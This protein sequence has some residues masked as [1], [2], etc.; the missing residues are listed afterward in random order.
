MAATADQVAEFLVAM[1]SGSPAPGSTAG[2]GRPLAIGTIRVIRAA[3]NHRYREA[4]LNSPARDTRVVTVM[5]GLE[6]L[7]GRQPRQAKALREREIVRIVSRC[8]EL[9]ARRQRRVI[10]VRDAAVVAVGFAAALRRSEICALEVA[11]VEFVRRGQDVSGMFVHIR[12]SKMDQ[13]GRG[14]TIAVPEGERIRPVGRLLEWLAVSG[15]DRGPLFRTLRRGGHVQGRPMHPSDIARLVKRWVKA[16][17]LDPE[18]YSGHSLRAGF[19]TSAAV[20]RA[21]L[22]KIMEVTRHKSADTV[23]RYV[24]QAD[25]FEDHAG[26][27]FL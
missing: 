9:A 5:R 11:D 16:I 8:D 25:A 22:D 27:G 15:V 7:A 3:I 20:H 19:V 2:V 17:G 18:G 1:A 26:S 24:R 23:L 12:R 13:A 14:Q 10:A 21:R 4:S 6:R